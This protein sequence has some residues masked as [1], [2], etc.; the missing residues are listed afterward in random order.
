MLG[1]GVT[2]YELLLHAVGSADDPASG[3]RQ[4]PSHWGYRD[5]NV[6]SQTSSTGS[7]CLPAVGCAEG[8]RYIVQHEGLP[9][10]RAHGDEVTYVSLG[11]GAT[12]EGEFWESLNA[13]CLLRLPVL[14]VVEDN[15]YAISV[16]ASDQSAAPISEL[17]AGFPGLA[18]HTFDG[19]DYFESYREGAAALSSTPPS[20]VRTPTPP[21]TPSPNTGWST[22]SP[23]RPGATRSSVSRTPSS[24]PAS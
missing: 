10:C 14:F 6:V 20:P 15:G 24:P 3:G 1:L 16:R 2:P 21:A 11:D 17:V 7:Q 5:K 9:G 12:S 8:A 4:M 23:R 19:T 22:T 13:A 18:V